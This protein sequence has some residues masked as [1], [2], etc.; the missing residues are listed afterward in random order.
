MCV[1]KT[2][3]LAKNLVVE[4]FVALVKKDCY[5]ETHFEVYTAENIQTRFPN[6]FPYVLSASIIQLKGDL[7]N[8]NG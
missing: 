4:L 5:G 7:K 6:P 2:P 8:T 3:L 1:Q